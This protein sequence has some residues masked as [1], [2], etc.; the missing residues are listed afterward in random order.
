MP[1]PFFSPAP[2]AVNF[3][4]MSAPETLIIV[5][6][7]WPFETLAEVRRDLRMQVKARAELIL[8]RLVDLLSVPARPVCVIV[9]PFLVSGGGL[10][11]FAAEQLRILAAAA[12]WRVNGGLRHAPLRHA[13]RIIA[14]RWT[15]PRQLRI[16]GFYRDLCCAEIAEG[17][18]YAGRHR[19]VIDRTLSRLCPPPEP[20]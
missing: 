19:I 20:V 14:E 5:H 16:A 9:G 13:G 17:A 2:R 1:P 7:S 8:C 4:G 3:P 18:G 15:Q 12:D 11:P 6:P 10:S